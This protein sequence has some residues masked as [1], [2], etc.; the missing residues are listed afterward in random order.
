MML[1]LV[2]GDKSNRARDSLRP[3]TVNG[4]I[5]SSRPSVAWSL[6]STIESIRAVMTLLPVQLHSY[7]KRFITLHHKEC[8]NTFFSDSLM[9]SQTKRS[10]STVEHA[11]NYYVPTPFR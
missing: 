5:N 10:I 3:S 1:G 11:R 4:A 6:D 9:V 8:F 7:S 2:I